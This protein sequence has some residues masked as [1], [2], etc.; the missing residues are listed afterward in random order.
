MKTKIK[1]AG[2]LLA[3]MMSATSIVN[4][5]WIHSGSQTILQY[6]SD[7]VGIGQAAPTS[8]LAIYDGTGTYNL[9][10]ITDNS[11]LLIVGSSTSANI[12]FDNNDIQARNN[13]ASANLLINQFGGKVG[14]GTA[15]PDAKLNIRSDAGERPFLVG[16]NGTTKLMVENNGG[17]SIGFTSGYTPPT[18]GLIVNGNMGVG[19]A[20]PVYNFQ[21]V[22]SAART[23]SFENTSTIVGTDYIGVYGKCQNTSAYGIGV[24]GEGGYVGVSGRA[25]LASLF[26]NR[27]VEGTAGYGSNCYGVWGYS[28]GGTNSNV[29]VFGQAYPGGTYTWGV[30]S[31]GDSYATGLWLSSDS[32]LKKD[33]EPFTNALDKIKQLHPRTYTF[34]TDEYKYMSLPSE[35]Q[36]G[37][38]AQELEKVFP[39]MVRGVQQPISNDRK[40]EMLD[41][42]AVNYIELIP[43]LTQAIQEQQAQMEAKDAKIAEQQKQLDMVNSR[44]DM[45][46]KSLSQCCTEFSN[47]KQSASINAVPARLEQ[48]APNPFTEK[49]VVKFYI[50]DT[51]KSAMI[52]IYSMN[53]EEM[54][55]FN[56]SNSGFGQVEI[57]GSSIAT[58]VY[59]Y[60]L[61]IDGKS[62]DSKQLIIT[63]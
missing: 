26:A 35:I 14:V 46:E 53:G 29:G 31:A 15:T 12:S 11:T 30:Y 54:K 34:K 43:V 28:S 10:S 32:K 47:E 16:I 27:G 50:P 3:I 23:G 61:L 44:L 45:I 4:A 63:K 56:I 6:T 40:S 62:V 37:F 22:G 55:S 49:T 39:S 5:Q 25:T 7:K 2:A 58:G 33:V 51:F 41:F 52:K 13:G 48:N 8:K 9:S 18:D 57:S 60:T 59:Q 17:T 21:A 19:T 1:L 42:K 36:Y 24:R 38:I 20:T